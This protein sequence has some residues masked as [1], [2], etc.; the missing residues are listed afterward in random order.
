MAGFGLPNFGQLT[1]AFRKA[2][3]IQQDAQ[4][5]QEE[6][7][8]M[9]IEGSSE[10]GRASIWLSGNQQPLRV[11]LDPSLLSEGQDTAEAAVL[12]ALQSAYERST[13]TMK[14]RMQDLTGGLDLNLPGWAADPQEFLHRSAIEAIA[15]PVATDSTAR[16]I[17]METIAEATGMDGELVPKFREQHFKI[18][19]IPRQVRSVEAG[20]VSHTGTWGEGMQLH[21]PR[22]MP[23]PLQ[24]SRHGA[25]PECKAWKQRI[26]QRTFA[27]P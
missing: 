19:G 24:P 11:K 2:Q 8:A 7:D 26:E 27:H 21:V 6:L 15:L 20:R 16:F 14:E 1:E 5:L 13:A 12:A 18:A 4:K 25:N 10:D 22:R 23:A 17:A 9:E 3:Q